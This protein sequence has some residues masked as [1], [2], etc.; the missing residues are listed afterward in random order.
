MQRLYRPTALLVHQN[1]TLTSFKELSLLKGLSLNESEFLCG[2]KR[3]CRKKSWAIH[4]RLVYSGELKSYVRPGI[5][6]KAD[7]EKNSKFNFRPSSIMC[8]RLY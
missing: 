8:A 1:A 3:E 2:K 6:D 4:K 7:T 5:L